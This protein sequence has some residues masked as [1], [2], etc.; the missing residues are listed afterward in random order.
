MMK[1]TDNKLLVN[2]KE[3]WQEWSSNRAKSKAIVVRKKPNWDFKE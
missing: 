3:N 1:I 2:Q